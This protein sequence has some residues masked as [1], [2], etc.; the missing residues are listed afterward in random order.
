MD[1]G[2]LNAGRTGGPN[3]GS[4]Q[5]LLEDLGFGAVVVD[6]ETDRILDINA[7]ALTMLQVTR[8]EGIGQ[9]SRRFIGPSVGS[10]TSAVPSEWVLYRS[11]GQS[12]PVLKSTLPVTIGGRKALLNSVIDISPRRQGETLRDSELYDALT[13]LA[14]RALFV[15]R[16]GRCIARAQR[17]KNFLFSVLLLDLDRFKFLNER[18]GHRMGEQTLVAVAERM[19]KTLR[20]VD[21]VALQG[22]VTHTL[23]RMGEDKFTILLEGIRSNEDAVRVARRIQTLFDQ[24][25]QVNDQEVFTSVSMGIATYDGKDT[26]AET[27]LRNADIALYR[28]RKMGRG[29]YAVFDTV[30]HAQAVERM[31]LEFDLRR[32]VELEQFSLVFQPIVSLVTGRI[33]GVETLVRWQHPERGEIMP[34]EFIPVAEEMGLIIPIGLFVLREACRQ[35][36]HWQDRFPCDPPLTVAVN[37]SGLQVR[38]PDLVGEI[39]KILREAGLAPRT[40]HLEITETALLEND[41]QTIKTLKALKKL[42]VGLHLD[43]FGKGYSSLSYLHHFPIDVLKIDRMFVQKLNGDPRKTGMVRSIMAMAHNRGMEVI[44]EGIETSSQLRCL[45]EMACEQGQGFFLSRP[46]KAGAVERLL[47]KQEKGA[48]LL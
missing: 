34:M 12:I 21:T 35:M 19:Q 43:D 2:K 9:E 33:I 11:D 16:L 41:R 1:G 27:M 32:A 40:L 36:K 31:N 26:T 28:A 46:K 6:A 38:Q 44:A 3:S 20:G 30:M 23:A 10:G 37:L 47:S 17:Q 15:D 14:N 24:P 29:S 22:D 5:D 8:E 4:Y 48:A 18:F 39:R 42:G 13:G 25:L 45:K 7:I